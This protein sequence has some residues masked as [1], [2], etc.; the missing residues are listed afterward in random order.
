MVAVGD[1]NAAR[2]KRLNSPP[3]APAIPLT[4]GLNGEIFLPRLGFPDISLH[5]GVSDIRLR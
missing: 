4:L 1:E 2:V 5:L 3:Y